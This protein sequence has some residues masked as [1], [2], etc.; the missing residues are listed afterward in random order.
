MFFG[1][2]KNS[3]DYG[4]GIS[5]DQFSSFKEIDDKEHMAIIHKANLEG[6][7]LGA[8]KS[9]NPI[10][11]DPPPPSQDEINSRKITEYESYLR[12]TDWYVIRYADSGKEI[13]HDIKIK[14]EEIR[15]KLSLLRNE[16]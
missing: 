6:K 7:I 13:P 8:D 14:R 5:K 16:K 10:L 2:L 4:F 3:N 15:E 1:K 9:G 12:K 11:M